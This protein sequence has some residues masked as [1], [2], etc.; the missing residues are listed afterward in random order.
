MLFYTHN[1]PIPITVLH[2]RFKQLVTLREVSK[3]STVKSTRYSMCLT[4]RRL[5]TKR[6]TFWTY[7]AKTFDEVQNYSM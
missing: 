1:F 2:H 5:S 6:P 7:V 4:A 3:S